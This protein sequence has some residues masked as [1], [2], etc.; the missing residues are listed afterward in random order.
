M[1]AALSVEETP[2]RMLNRQT[3]S[4]ARIRFCARSVERLSRVRKGI[5]L[6]LFVLAAYLWQRRRYSAE[7]SYSLRDDVNLP[8][9]LCSGEECDHF[10]PIF[11]D[12]GFVFDPD[13]TCAVI[14]WDAGRLGNRLISI[15]HMFVESHISG[16]HV[17]LPREPL[18]DNWSSQI[19][20][21]ENT[22]VSI[23][24]KNGR[25]PTLTAGDWHRRFRG[26]RDIAK[27]ST[28]AINMMRIYF[29]VNQTHALDVP[30]PNRRYTALHLRSGD[31]TTGSYSSRTGHFVPGSRINKEY[32][33]FPA[34]FYMKA[35]ESKALQSVEVLCETVGNPVC[36]L[37]IQLAQVYKTFKVRKGRPL[38]SDVHHLLCATDVA[39][40]KGTFKFITELSVKNE[41]SHVF[42]SFALHRCPRLRTA[43]VFHFIRNAK[44]RKA[45]TEEIMNGWSNNE[46][47]RHI[48]MNPYQMQT[49]ECAG[50]S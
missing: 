25:C 8:E 29:R 24:H 14:A 35:S 47:Q 42:I 15:S 7:I 40:S 41:L 6:I 50:L 34:S 43:T 5:R 2:P 3:R 49:L 10:R 31:V 11:E 26:R 18:L 46:Y 13:R 22:A 37:F 44:Q 23:D 39:T 27:V 45:Y 36:G 16:C 17:E 1:D 4:R 12:D 20:G 33:L 28:V 38:K 19:R 21:F 30:C 48:V 9:G 32:G